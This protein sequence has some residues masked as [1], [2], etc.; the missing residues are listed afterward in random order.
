MTITGLSWANFSIKGVVLI[1]KRLSLKRKLSLFVTLV[2]LLALSILTWTNTTQ[3]RATMTE[4]LERELLSVGILTSLQL[5]TTSIQ[6]LQEENGPE[7]ST[8]L[9]LQEQLDDIQNEQG[10][11]AW[12]YIWSGVD[13][14]DSVIPLAYT[15]NLNEVY[16]PGE[17]FDDLALEHT[18]AA[19][20]TINSGESQVTDIFEDPYGIWQ[21]VFSPI[22]D[23][24]QVIAV[25]GIDYSAEYIQEGLQAATLQQTLTAAFWVIA[26]GAAVYFIISR[27]FK[28]LTEMVKVADRI[29]DGD[30]TVALTERKT[31]DEIGKLQSSL[32]TMQEHLRNVVHRTQ[33][34]SNEVAASSE[35]LAASSEEMS[36]FSK[37]VQSDS[38]SVEESTANNASIISET[39]LVLDETAEGVQRIAESA[40]NA[41]TESN[42]MTGEAQNGNQFVQGVVSQMGVIS[43]SVEGMSDSLS[44]LEAEVNEIS[45]FTHL[46]TQVSEQT[47]LLALNASIEAARAGEHGRGFAVVATEIRKLAEHTHQS[48][49]EIER[50][51]SSIQSS[52]KETVALSSQGTKDVAEGLTLVEKTGES[53]TRIL[54]SIE[55]VASQIQEISASSE[56]ISASSEE[57]TASVTELSH[58]AEKIARNAKDVSQSSSLQLHTIQEVTASAESLSELGLAL[59]EVIHRFKV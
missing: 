3:L 23:G 29:A 1:L 45:D 26:A 58:A 37:N 52:S 5:D 6:T 33:D 19:R 13:E 48:V 59:Q 49:K 7:N 57:V 40:N 22:Y 35:E 12:S 9:A 4:D 14:G 50:R 25:I 36:N 32:Q 18:E 28:P 24:E 42:H 8:F 41:A 2:V 55:N 46:I 17:E 47:N 15:S 51:V 31:E 34:I 30:L 20:A 39:A 21:T 38:G 44:Q 11:M 54:H 16:A 43:N 53:F 27:M 56:E 10:T